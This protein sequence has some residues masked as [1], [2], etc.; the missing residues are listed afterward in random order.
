LQFKYCKINAR[1]L[2]IVIKLSWIIVIINS[3]IVIFC[4]RY[5]TYIICLNRPCTYFII[6]IFYRCR[7]HVFHKGYRRRKGC[8]H[9]TKHFM[10]VFLVPISAWY[11]III[12]IKLSLANIIC[13]TRPTHVF[14]C[15]VPIPAIFN[16]PKQCL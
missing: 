15:K 11:N 14:L 8:C 9:V 16:V 4:A 7:I 3:N 13:V 1:V 6:F 2:G 12:F 10:R 5:I